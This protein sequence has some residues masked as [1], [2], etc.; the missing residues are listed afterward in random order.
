MVKQAM[1]NGQ[2]IPNRIANAPELQPGLEIYLQAFIELDSERS[3]VNGVVAIPTLKIIEYAKAFDFNQE[4]KEDLLYLIRAVDSAHC[5]KLIS[6]F[7][8]KN[9]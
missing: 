3:H 4:Q 7:K 9:K 5:K 6:E 8:A 2:P 1:R